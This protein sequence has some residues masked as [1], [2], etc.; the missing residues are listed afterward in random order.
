MHF[1]SEC[2]EQVSFDSDDEE[3]T[4]EVQSNGHMSPILR[5]L[6]LFLLMWQYFFNVPDAGLSL[7]ILFVFNV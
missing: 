1:Q 2:L 5:S 4:S 6:L 3:E 7:L